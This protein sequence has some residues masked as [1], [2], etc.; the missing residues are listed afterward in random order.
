MKHTLSFSRIVFSAA[1]LGAGLSSSFADETIRDLAKE[2]GRFIGTILNSEWFNALPAKPASITDKREMAT[3]IWLN[4]ESWKV[5]F[6]FLSTHK[7]EDLEDGK[8]FLT[9]DQKTFANVQ[10]YVPRE[11]GKFERHCKYIDLQYVFEGAEDHQVSKLENLV[12]EVLPYSEERDVALC[13]SSKDFQTIRVDK[14]CF[15]LYFPA[16]AHNPNL[17]IGGMEKVRKVVVK[18]P[19]VNR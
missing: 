10:T 19:Y 7:L 1:L 12:D 17:Q 13:N 11:S 14:T 3:Q 6:E 2:R 16:D 5:A 18:I 15:G 9:P 8:I 4:P